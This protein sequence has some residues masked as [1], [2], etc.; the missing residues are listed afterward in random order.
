MTDD[1]LLGMARATMTS[2]NRGINN[3]WAYRYATRQRGRGTCYPVQT[4]WVH[5]R[6]AL[7]A[8]R[9]CDEIRETI[10]PATIWSVMF[11]WPAGP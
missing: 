9:R 6:R 3:L 2:A 10:L 5:L 7:S 11:G 4:G 8:V 1:F